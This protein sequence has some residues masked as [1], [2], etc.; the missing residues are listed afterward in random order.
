MCGIAGMLGLRSDKKIQTEMLSTMHR[1]GPDGCGIYQEGEC[2]LLHSR[3]A[4]IDPQG[5]AQPMHLSWGDEG[6]TIVYNGELYNTNE[7][8]EQLLRCGHMFHT[9]S[10]T[11]V[12]LH[13][14]AQ[15][16]ESCLERFNGIFAFG[17][18]EH[19]RKRLFLGRDRIGVKPLFYKLHNKGILFASEIRRF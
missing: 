9:T 8:R 6:Y 1:R 13:A 3:L 16:K 5:G 17:V 18:W 2:C 10:D 12:V 14:Y 4:I 7:I 19:N 11:E 15:W